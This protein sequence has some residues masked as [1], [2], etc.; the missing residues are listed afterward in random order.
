MMN[1]MN[2]SLEDS[3]KIREFGEKAS[4]ILVSMIDYHEISSPEDMF[5]RYELFESYLNDIRKIFPP[6]A[7][8]YMLMYRDMEKNN[9]SHKYYDMKPILK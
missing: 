3:I 9:F 1:K 2:F 8:S 6:L 7:D 4:N 5:Y